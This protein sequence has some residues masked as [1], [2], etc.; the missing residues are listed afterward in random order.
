MRFIRYSIRSA[1]SLKWLAKRL[2]FYQSPLLRF[3]VGFLSFSSTEFDHSLSPSFNQVGPF[4]HS[5]DS[6]SACAGAPLGD[7]IGWILQSRTVSP[8]A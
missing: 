6:S 7:E 2:L 8:P 1:C 5:C 3:V 4:H